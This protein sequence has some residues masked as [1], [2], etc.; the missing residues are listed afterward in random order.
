ML[1][2]NIFYNQVTELPPHRSRWGGGQWAPSGGK[3]MTWWRQM[4]PGNTHSNH[5]TFLPPVPPVFALWHRR[6]LEKTRSPWDARQAPL[7]MTALV[8]LSV[9]FGA[10]RPSRRSI[11]GIP[12]ASAPKTQYWTESQWK[13]GAESGGTESGGT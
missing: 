9:S 8:P 3:K 6:A 4:L 12:T 2:G 5:V 7:A 11:L 13:R 10:L 1:C